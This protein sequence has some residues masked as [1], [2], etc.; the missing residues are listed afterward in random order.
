MQ[1][2]ITSLGDL[3]HAKG[4]HMISTYG[5][6]VSNKHKQALN[7]LTTLLNEHARDGVTMPTCKGHAHD[8]VSKVSNKHKQALNVL[9][10]LLNEHAPDG[11]TM[12]TCGVLPLEKSRRKINRGQVAMELAA[13][14]ALAPISTSSAILRRFLQAEKAAPL[15][16]QY[17][18]HDT[19]TTVVPTKRDKP[20]HNTTDSDECEDPNEHMRVPHKRVFNTQLSEAPDKWAALYD[21]L[22][23]Q[24]GFT[25]EYNDRQRRHAAQSRKNIARNDKH[26]HM[27]QDCT[28]FLQGNQYKFTQDATQHTP[29]SLK[30]TTDHTDIFHWTTRQPTQAVRIMSHRIQPRYA[31]Q[32]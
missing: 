27:Q 4:T 12:P 32:S 29:T 2:G 11:V 9:T 30:S 14:V 1:L 23:R 16:N 26:N 24:R 18:S 31:N 19:H 5:S 7:V 17:A 13:E 10:T 22:K 6:K 20:C 3:T 28:T 21:Q 25:R 15:G 8:K